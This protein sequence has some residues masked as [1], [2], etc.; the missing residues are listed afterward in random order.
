MRPPRD[1]LR[2]GVVGASSLLGKDLIALLKE[3]NFP[4]QQLVTAESEEG[5][6][7]LP[8]VDLREGLD[9]SMADEN[10]GEKD[11]NLVFV[12]AAPSAGSK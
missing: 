4:V 8:I 9:A 12:A 3:R 10:L 11:F 7:D 6:P 1:G 2:V 5:E